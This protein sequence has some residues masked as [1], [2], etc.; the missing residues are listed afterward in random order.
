[1]EKGSSCT[2]EV[3][4]RK[5][6][7]WAG[8]N[9]FLR[10]KR[11]NTLL[12]DGP[13][14]L[15]HFLTVKLETWGQ[16][17]NIVEGMTE[18]GGSVHD[19]NLLPMTKEPGVVGDHWFIWCQRLCAV[20]VCVSVCVPTVLNHHVVCK[21]WKFWMIWPNLFENVLAEKEERALTFIEWP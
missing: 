17:L 2:E 14:F 6:S 8:V 10:Q 3:A 7:L 20:C 12:S 5:R 18:C 13:I 16:D 15:D 1:M 21:I 19:H 4:G 9:L 11:E